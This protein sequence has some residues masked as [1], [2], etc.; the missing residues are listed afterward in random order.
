LDLKKILFILPSLRAGGAER[1]LSFVAQNLD[2]TKF[3]TT[4]LV[5][6]FKKDAIYEVKSINV[7]FLN[8]RRLLSSLWRI[9]KFI[10]RNKPNIVVSSIIHVNIF[11]GVLAFFFRKINF[12]AREASVISK[13]NEYSNNVI[14]NNNIILSS[15]YSNFSKIICQST[16]M[17]NDIH[18]NYKISKEK[19]SIIN[20]P[21]TK[22]H[23]VKSNWNKSTE[24]VRFVTVGR[25]SKEKGHSRILESLSRMESYN[26]H[27][28]IIGDGPLKDELP[29]LVDSL[30]LNDKVTFVPYMHNVSLEL[31]NK[32]VF[33]QGSYVEG[34]PNAVLE[35]CVVGTPVI[36]FNA[37]GGTSEIIK[38][39][40]NGIIVSSVEEFVDVL[41]DISKILEMDPN[42]ISAYVND[43]FKSSYILKQY[44]EM[45]NSII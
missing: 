37:I 44:E 36:A 38:K 28:T 42:E 43:K 27:Y 13:M 3:S 21:I 33:L 15:I 45:F 12:V 34:F 40:V 31:A 30:G 24:L 16:D 17:Y 22:K 14:L 2:K 1:V 9:L 4:L 41:K 6:G 10:A 32:D 7:V 11:T 26:Y 8:K 39:G 20:N 19:L 23:G 25:L 18:I 5:L 35:S 29:L